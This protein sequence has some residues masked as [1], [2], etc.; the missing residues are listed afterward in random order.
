[1]LARLRIEM[2]D[3]AVP[4][5][6]QPYHAVEPLPVAEA[7][8]RLGLYR[9]EAEAMARGAI[10]RLVHELDRSG[11]SVVSLG[12]L[13]SSG[14]KGGSLAAILESHSLIHTADGDHYR[15]A[16]AAAAEVN[17]LVVS[18]VRARDLDSQAAKCLERPA[19]RLRQAVLRMGREAGPPWG[20]DQ[21]AAALL[22]WLLLAPRRAR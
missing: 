11:H 14:R 16:L 3:P 4:E 20:A 19:A 8:R 9:K 21:K 13:E 18:R 5:S 22:A 15:D 10:R 17:E 7:A 2:Y 1:M 12:I 6:K